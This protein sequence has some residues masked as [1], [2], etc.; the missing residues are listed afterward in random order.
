M[1]ATLLASQLET[2]EALD[3]DERHIS[4]GINNSPELI[5]GQ[6]L[7]QLGRGQPGDRQL[8]R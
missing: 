1:P 4:A 7:A 6:V 2:L 8:V 3:A 5:V